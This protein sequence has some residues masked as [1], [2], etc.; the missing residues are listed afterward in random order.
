MGAPHAFD[1][2]NAD[3]TGI[4]ENSDLYISKVIHQAVVEVNE[5]GTEAAAATAVIM[6]RRSAMNIDLPEEFICNRPF[7]FV[8]HEKQCNGV[9]F[10]GKYVKPQ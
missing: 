7:L 10:I 2:Q 3:F 8:I 1:M 4:A 9:L 5:E 6:M